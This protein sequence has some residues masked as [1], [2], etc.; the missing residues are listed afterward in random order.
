MR[1]LD[2]VKN[3]F[4][5]II[6]GAGTVPEMLQ[7][8]DETLARLSAHGI[9][10]NCDKCKFF[11]SSVIYMRHVLSAQG[12]SPDS[13]KV[14]AI[15][16]LHPPTN[17]KKLRSFFSMITYLT[18]FILNLAKLTEPFCVLT[19]KHAVWTWT[20]QHQNSFQLL[21]E[22]LFSDTILAYFN[23]DAPTRIVTDASHMVLV[24]SCYNNSHLGKTD[25]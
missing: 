23:P 21:K 11:Q 6:I 20:E 13:V 24:L 5:D 22:Q 12:L 15:N 8:I 18:A 10:V 3:T 2:R 17:A 7:R 1:G 16:L 19:A 25:R 14:S 9:T 4:D